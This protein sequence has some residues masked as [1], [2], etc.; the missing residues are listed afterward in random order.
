MTPLSLTEA[1][2]FPRVSDYFVCL[3]G[4]LIPVTNSIPGPLEDLSKFP[5][6]H[7]DPTTTTYTPIATQLGFQQPGPHTAKHTLSSWGG[8]LVST[9][10]PLPGSWSRTL[11]LECFLLLLIYI[12]ILEEFHPQTS[13]E[14]ACIM[15]TFAKT[16]CMHEQGLVNVPVGCKLQPTSHIWPMGYFLF[17]L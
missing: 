17:I 14:E 3:P 6:V 5:C 16:S 7:L 12:L 9:G 13:S 4:F 1:L 8:F 11:F 10:S 15:G 2:F